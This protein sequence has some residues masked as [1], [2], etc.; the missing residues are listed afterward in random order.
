MGY[1]DLRLTRLGPN[2]DPD[3][4]LKVPFITILIK[5]KDFDLPFNDVIVLEKVACSISLLALYNRK[6]KSSLTLK[7]ALTYYRHI[8]IIIVAIWMIF[9]ITLC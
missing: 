2:N 7:T 1:K 8:H 4:K 9:Y 5:E 3:S 6:G